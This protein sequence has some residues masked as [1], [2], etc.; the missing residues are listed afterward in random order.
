MPGDETT[1]C[2][3]SSCMENRT[4]PY[5]CIVPRR[6]AWS[7]NETLPPIESQGQTDKI[8]EV[9]R[10]RGYKCSGQAVKAAFSSVK[11]LDRGLEWQYGPNVSDHPLPQ[12]WDGIHVGI[13]V[14]SFPDY[15][16]H[17]HA[18][19]PAHNHSGLP[20]A[21]GSAAHSREWCSLPP[22]PV[23]PSRSPV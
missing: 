13:E 17:T 7:E 8:F 11:N 3:P 12:T 14:P 21:G 5:T 4:S 2:T 6:H 23:S 9:K 18:T 16:R 22:H 19:A 15:N 20:V 1:S 10:S